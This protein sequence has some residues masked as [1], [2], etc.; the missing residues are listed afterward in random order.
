Y[1][2][3]TEWAA[4]ARGLDATFVCLQYGACEDEVAAFEREHGLMVHMPPGLD[5]RDD[6]EG[7]AGLYT[8][9][10]AVV[11]ALNTIADFAGS[12]GV[13]GWVVVDAPHWPWPVWNACGPA[14]QCWYA[15]LRMV[16]ARAEGGWPAAF[17]RVRR[18][19]E[20]AP[21]G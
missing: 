4:F 2:P 17:A 9:L 16:D 14:G 18:E 3:M 10:D 15:G 13:R 11:S 1:A 20:C 6:F 19:L 21:E 7:M 12:L 8:A 5:R